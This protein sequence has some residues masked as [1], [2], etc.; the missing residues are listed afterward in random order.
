MKLYIYVDDSLFALLQ[1]HRLLRIWKL[2]G[3]NT[4]FIFVWE[5]ST[6]FFKKIVRW[7]SLSLVQFYRL[8][9]QPSF[10]IDYDFEVSSNSNRKLVGFPTSTFLSTEIL[11]D[12]WM[13]I[14]VRD[15]L[16]KL[17]HICITLILSYIQ[18]W[19]IIFI[20]IISDD[21]AK[22]LFI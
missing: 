6:V 9:N 20:T 14:Y 10:T 12:L 18:Q 16:T 15:I 3:K 7:Y 1:F 17:W 22:E 4:F 19:C 2:E 21:G 8:Q 13:H 11:R 5:K